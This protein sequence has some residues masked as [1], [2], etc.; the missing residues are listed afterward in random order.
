MILTHEINELFEELRKEKEN[1]GESANDAINHGNRAYGRGVNH[2]QDD[3]DED[4]T[5]ATPKT[6]DTRD[7]IKN[8]QISHRTISQHVS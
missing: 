4:Y 1:G 7:L 2:G 3:S 8:S 5:G 6:P